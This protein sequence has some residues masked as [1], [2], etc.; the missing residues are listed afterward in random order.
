MFTKEQMAEFVKT[1]EP[2]RLGKCLVALYDR[3]TADEKATEQTRHHNKLGFSAVDAEILSSMARFF[4]KRGFLSKK[5]VDIVRK[6]LKKYVGQLADI[7]NQ[8][9]SH[10]S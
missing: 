3:Q 10:A 5:Q 2:T 8:R 1:C 6:K 4:T 9:G 7:A